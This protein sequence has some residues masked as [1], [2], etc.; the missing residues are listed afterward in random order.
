M[1]ILAK[2]LT[3]FAPTTAELT[4]YTV[5][6]TT[7]VIVTNILI[8]NTSAVPVALSMSFVAAGSLAGTANRVVPGT[9]IPANTLVPI[10][11]AA[12]LAAGDFISAVAAAT[13]LVVYISGT[14]QAAASAVTTGSVIKAT[15]LYRTRLYARENYL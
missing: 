14:E 12:V 4:Y 7:A 11:L 15:R 2:K 3:Q 1:P 5:P 6:A 8:S 10:D 9:T 13:G